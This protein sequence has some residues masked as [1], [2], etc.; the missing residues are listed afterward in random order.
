MTTA[1]RLLALVDREA[2]RLRA[3]S[4]AAASAPRAPGKW[5]PKQVLGHLLDSANANLQRFVRG[6]LEPS[7]AVPD[8]QQDDWV[9]VQGYAEADWSE[10]VA[11]W[12]S[13]NRHAARVIARI[14]ATALTHPVRLGDKE[15]VPLSRIVEHYLEHVEHHLGQIPA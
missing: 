2:P 4:P 11:L 15:P 12:V 1:D 3:L 14:P 5:S 8:Y 7:L 9:R 10:L 13:L 6:Q